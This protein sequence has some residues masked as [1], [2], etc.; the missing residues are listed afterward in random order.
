MWTRTQVRRKVRLSRTV[1]TQYKSMGDVRGERKAYATTR[2]CARARARVAWWSSRA[3][4]RSRY[5]RGYMAR[6]RNKQTNYDITATMK[7]K[8][9]G[10]N[11]GN[12]KTRNE[13]KSTRKQHCWSKE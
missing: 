6:A 3:R 9:N 8:S 1:S 11:M 13:T 10:K 12:N 4:T 2:A 7:A 5:T